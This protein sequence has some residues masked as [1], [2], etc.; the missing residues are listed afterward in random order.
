MSVLEPAARVLAHLER[1]RNRL[2]DL[3]RRNPLIAL[4]SGRLNHVM[5]SQPVGQDVFDRL[6]ARKPWHFWA[7]ADSGKPSSPDDDE[8]V[9]EDLDRR[10]LA[11]VLTHLYRR[12]KADFQERGLHPLHVVF[13]TVEWRELPIAPPV[14]S[15]LLLLPVT[16]TRTAAGAPFVLAATEGEPLVNPA[17]AARFRHDFGFDL[18]A[19]TDQLSLADWWQAVQTVAGDRPDWVWERHTLLTPLS[20]DKGVIHADMGTH[21]ERFAT[22]PLVQALAGVSA[23]VFTPPEQV[24]AE[25]TLDALPAEPF[26]VLDAD[27]SQRRCLEAARRG[28]SFVLIGPPGTGKSQT[29]A[30]L[31]AD[32]LAAGQS[33]LFVSAKL[34][35]LDVVYRR[36]R[37]VGLGDYCLELHSAGTERSRVVQELHRSLFQ[38]PPALPA[39]PADALA[40]W[41]QHR[42][43]L[44]AYVTALHTPRLPL[45]RSVADVSA[46]LLCHQAVPTVPYIGPAVL[47]AGRAWLDEVARLARQVARLTDVLDAGRHYVWFGLHTTEAWSPERREQL[48]GTLARVRLAVADVERVRA[49]V[50]GPVG[51]DGELD[52]LEQAATHLAN[53]PQPPSMWLTARWPSEFGAELRRLAETHRCWQ[54][55]RLTLTERYGPALWDVPNGTAA[56]LTTAW[57]AVAAQLPTHVDGGQMLARQSDLLAWGMAT[58]A[59]VPSWH[60]TA[61]QFA[62]ALGIH[63]PTPL[64]LRHLQHLAQL[65]QLLPTTAL[66]AAWLR[67]EQPRAVRAQLDALAPLLTEYQRDRDRLLQ[68]YDD[69]LF[70]LDLDGLATRFAH[71]HQG[72]LRYAS[73]AYYC[74]RAAV[75]S[76]CRTGSLPATVTADLHTARH[77]LRLRDRLTPE[78]RLLD[79][80]L[81]RFGQGFDTPIAAVRTAL[82]VVEQ[83]QQ[84][85]GWLGHAELPTPLAALLSAGAALPPD[86][87]ALHQSLTQQLAAWQTQT[88]KLADVLPPTNVDAPLTELSAASQRLT[89]GLEQLGRALLPVLLRPIVRPTDLRALIDDLRQ[90]ELVRAWLADEAAAAVERTSKLGHLYAGSDDTDWPAVV[91]QWEWAEQARQLF[92]A[93]VPNAYVTAAT[94]AVPLAWPGAAGLQT[95]RAEVS[96]ARAALATFFGPELPTSL[97]ALATL[98]ERLTEALPEVVDWYAVQALPGA[99]AHLHLADWWHR[100][101]QADVPWEQTPAAFAKAFAL[102]WLAAQQ[103]ADPALARFSGGEHDH[104]RAE[105]A[106][107]ERTLT[108]GRAATVAAALADH[109][110]LQPLPIPGSEVERL[111]KQALIKTRHKPL[112]QLL[113][114]IPTLLP[115]LKPCLLMSPLSVSQFLAETTVQF[116]VVVFDEASQLPPEE[117]LP[118]LARGKQV[119]IAGDDQQL[120]PALFFASGAQEGDSLDDYASILDQCRGVLPSHLLRWHYRSRNEALIAFS[121]RHFYHDELVTFPT[122]N[123]QA[124]PGV[125]LHRLAD[126]VYDRG[127]RRDNRREAAVV[128]ELVCQQ[129]RTQPNK[130]VG[131][132]AFS[133]AQMWA[134][135]QQL[136][137]LRQADLELE[138]HFSDDRLDGVFVRNLE[139]VQ[140]DERD[141]I[142]LSIGYGPDERGRVPHNFGPLNRVGG[143]KR[144]NVAVTRAREQLIVVTSLRPG[145]LGTRP[146]EPLGVQRLREYLDYAERGPISL[147]PAPPALR[148]P[149]QLSPLLTQV[150]A[151]LHR[152]GYATT[153]QVGLGGQRI[154]L[155]V[156]ERDCPERLLV[157]IT[158]DGPNYANSATVRDRDRLRPQILTALGWRLFPIWTPDWLT[159]PRRVREQLRHALTQPAPAVPTAL[160]V[161]VSAPTEVVVPGLDEPL[162]GTVPYSVW[163]GTVAEEWRSFEFAGP[164]A[165]SEQLRK[166]GEIVQHEGPI[167]AETALRR[168]GKAWGVDRWLERHKQVAEELLRH[169]DAEKHWRHADGFLWPLLPGPTQV[170]VPSADDEATH[171]SAER[172]AEAEWQAALVLVV[173]A[174]VSVE[175]EPL[176][177]QTAKVFG[178]RP[179]DAVRD[180]LTNVLEELL[181]AGTLERRGDDIRLPQRQRVAVA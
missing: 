162:A 19:W 152:W 108:A 169:P 41:H 35:A 171:R 63:L 54:Q 94:G 67:A 70:A 128:A 91:A 6:V 148:P 132:I 150:Q 66:P 78:L 135:E 83:A 102:A 114:E 55:V 64:T 25:H 56:T 40:R 26:T 154:D 120:P 31:I 81:G 157:G 119:I 100:L 95:A 29:I 115:Q 50:A 38:R 51:A 144:L 3:S 179:T 52:W 146:N 126:G 5:L 149:T 4:R 159:H 143:E 93:G 174:G 61:Q 74:D 127:G 113:A 2:L 112:R 168:L 137:R 82:N 155:A 178:L 86:V 122:A 68:T 43:T 36:L 47:T 62:T 44:N 37:Q 65:G 42:D 71:A 116:D 111:H 69:C 9:C 145:D 121:N 141:V 106:A 11:N 21:A 12:G 59:G 123:T 7:P 142:F 90:T 73:V 34:A 105:F 167:H 58:S 166:L 49:A 88:D 72:W 20:F 151:E 125:R 130:T 17:L 16:L 181:V 97:P 84:L 176:L 173:R 80:E 180:R 163:S 139:T 18:P 110:P 39:A 165:R 13:G 33:V 98:A 133:Q 22:H 147:P 161:P 96:A 57:H 87:A 164:L 24:P 32:R 104:T 138:R 53:S 170:R 23:D 28:H 14:R 77:L 153:P 1:W 134:I 160:S 10:A 76:A 131:V 129:L 117:A 107:L 172:I 124:A 15:P 8:L 118:A 158:T 101:Q 48:A 156:Y 92:P 175:P 99:W 89:A 79:A 109:R 103:A 46:E 85:A 75:L 177:K 30:N 60:T 45:G 140:G 136:E 27:A